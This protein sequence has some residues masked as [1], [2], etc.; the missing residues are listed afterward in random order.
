MLVNVLFAIALVGTIILPTGAYFIQKREKR[1][2]RSF[3]RSLAANIASFVIVFAAATVVLFAG[4]ASAAEG[5]TEG[6][7]NGLGYIGAAIAIGCSCL[8]SGIAVA[9]SA[10]AALGAL[11]EDQSVFGKALIFV[12]LA[13]GIALWGFIVAFLIINAL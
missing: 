1:T 3:K 11:S 4:S 2:K 12:A 10:S 6:L 5:A 8:G 9:S 13:E 7:A